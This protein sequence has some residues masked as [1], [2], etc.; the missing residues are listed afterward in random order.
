MPSVSHNEL[1]LPHTAR[2]SSDPAEG[3]C[4]MAW[5]KMEGE[6][7]ASLRHPCSYHLFLLLWFTDSIVGTEHGIFYVPEG[8][9]SNLQCL[10]PSPQESKDFLD[11]MVSF[12][13]DVIVLL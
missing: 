9:H 8:S 5:D 4:E 12:L 7:T 1:C 6:A 2:V 13:A 3:R 11:Q 10:Y